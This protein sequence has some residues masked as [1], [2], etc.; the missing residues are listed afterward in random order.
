MMSGKKAKRSRA[1]SKAT[2]EPAKKPLARLVMPLIAGIVVVVGIVLIIASNNENAMSGLQHS[3]PNAQ[4]TQRVSSLEELLKMPPEQLAEVDIAEMNLLCATGLPGAEKLDVGE[5]LATLDKWAAW[6]KSETDRHLY[7]FHQAPADYNR[8]EGYYR[9]LML[10]TVLQ[11]DFGVHY[12]AERIRNVDFTK[13][14]DLFI[15]GMIDDTNGGT[16][17]SMPVIYTAIA[18]RLGYPVRLALAKGHVFCRWEAPSERFNVE[19]TNQGMNTFDDE[20]YKTWPERVSD[21]EIR[22]NRYLVSL[23]PAEELAMFLASRGHC[24][25][26][27]GR[28]KE[29]SQAYA[30]AHRCD[31]QNPAYR[32]WARQLEAPPSWRSAGRGG[33][34]AVPMARRV[35]NIPTVSVTDGRAADNRT[36]PA[37]HGA[38]PDDPAGTSHR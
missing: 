18:R 22:A 10:I 24:L 26:D 31:P 20:Y 7:K 19:A 29:A 35:G 25:L 6:V 37:M 1:S 14:Q 30:S 16:C 34:A 15:H 5:R 11:Q 38:H 23:S 33:S 36:R 32:D 12:N 21:A 9:M 27:N 13:S 17:V 3:T 8:S 28:T 4:Y 2:P